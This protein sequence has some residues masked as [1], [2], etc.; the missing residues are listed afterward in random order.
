MVSANIGSFNGRLR[1]G[2]I[3]GGVSAN[4]VRSR[5]MARASRVRPTTCVETEPALLHRNS[6]TGFQTIP[7]K[8]G[9][10]GHIPATQRKR[11]FDSRARSGHVSCQ[12][13]FFL[14]N[15]LLAMVMNGFRYGDSLSKM[16]KAYDI[17]HCTI[18]SDLTRRSH[19]QKPQFPRQVRV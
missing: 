10:W 19:L 18:A 6:F 1:F 3:S 7:P 5:A 4:K 15:F 16:I 8:L 17:L 9:P 11:L 2:R 12:C 13:R 14:T